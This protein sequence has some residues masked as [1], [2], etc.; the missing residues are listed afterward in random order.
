MA[1]NVKCKHC[2][3][4]RPAL[5]FAPF[6][7]ELGQRIA[8]EIC[9]PCWA[10]WLQKQTQIINHY[11]LDLTSTDAQNFLFDNIKGYLFDEGL[12]TAEQA[13]IDTSKEGSVKW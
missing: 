9:Q 3:E 10:G 8:T 7:N 5:G 4:K 2:G 6:P 13:E 12:P 11:G 1:E